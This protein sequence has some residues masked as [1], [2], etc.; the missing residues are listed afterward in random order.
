MDEPEDLLQQMRELIKVEAEDVVDRSAVY[1]VLWYRGTR[2][3]VLL[4]DLADDIRLI[5]QPGGEGNPPPVG[6]VNTQEL[7]SYLRREHK[8]LKYTETMR[9]RNLCWSELGLSTMIERLKV[10]FS[11]GSE[12]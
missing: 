7:L 10:E 5:D 6:V 12:E 9:L 1:D 4:E 3:Q 8:N 11:S 2:N